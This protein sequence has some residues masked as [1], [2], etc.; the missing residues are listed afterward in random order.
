MFQT[1]STTSL[2]LTKLH[3]DLLLYL[4]DFL[5]VTSLLNFSLTCKKS[6]QLIN[7]NE[8]YWRLRY[9][10]E[11]ALDDDW[12]E[13]AWL[14]WYSGQTAPKQS[15]STS[16][17]KTLEQKATRDWSYVH[18]RKAYY[19]RH[20][21]YKHLIHGSWRKGYCYLPVDDPDKDFLYIR[22]MSSR[23]TLISEDDGTRKWLV[24]HDIGLPGIK[25][26][27]LAWY[28]LP[29]PTHPIGKV[30][31]TLGLDISDSYAIM[32]CTLSVNSES[33]NDDQSKS[34]RGGRVSSEKIYRRA[35]ILAWNIQDVSRVIPLYIQPDDEARS[36]APLP[37]LME[38]RDNWI[39]GSINL[40]SKKRRDN[41]RHKYIIFDLKRQSYYSFGSI[42]TSSNA[43]IQY[44]TEDY[45]HV[46]TLYINSDDMK[47]R[48]KDLMMTGDKPTGLRLHWHS[49]IFD[50]EHDTSLE[51][52]GGEIVLPYYYDHPIIESRIYVPGL[53]LVTI[54][55]DESSSSRRKGTKSHPI[56]ALV[57]VPHHGLP[58]HN[59][60]RHCHARYAGA[61]GE[62]VWMQPIA[63]KYVIPLPSQNMIAVQ[64]YGK[65]DFLNDTD[66]KIVRQFDCAV[67]NILEP[68]IGPY[69]YL[70][71]RDK[72]SFIVNIET[73]EKFQHSIKLRPPKKHINT[74]PVKKR[75]VN[76]DSVK[77]KRPLDDTT[78][79]MV[80]TDEAS[81]DN[82]N[83]SSD[84]DTAPKKPLFNYWYTESPFTPNC[85]PYCN[86]IGKL[87]LHEP[88]H[89]N[90]FSV[91]SMSGF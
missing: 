44:V 45:A 22:C 55:D 70:L 62:V 64:Q 21:V 81:V 49:Y 57:R 69:C 88:G 66:G 43:H 77:K 78:S 58:Q 41:T 40:P 23:A 13:S 18:W 71:D 29:M 8:T 89:R 50:D 25:S 3:C 48:K 60:S 82:A 30:S 2:L 79:A 35:A 15:T 32:K 80:I 9:Y 84:S 83:D 72:N 61:I 28:E 39:L 4:C 47:V 20:M 1:K 51:D 19:R 85:W 76:N 16:Q 53:M 38:F 75:R 17:S 87:A 91:Y 6:H 33:N 7:E 65:I 34:S 10:K 54:Y 36:N 37:K 74:V 11:F 31:T 42:Y 68:I 12:R 26:G 27:Q 59:I 5:D 86:C 14:L 24:R 67:Y 46:I 56:L 52:D 73:G 90:R 63:T